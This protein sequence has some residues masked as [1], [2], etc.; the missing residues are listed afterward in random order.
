MTQRPELDLTVVCAVGRMAG[1][2]GAIHRAF[3]EVVARTD[4]T[5]EFV[6]VLHGSRPAAVEALLRTPAGSIPRRIF[7][8]AKGFGEAAA[9]DLGFSRARGR[10]VI[11]IPERLQVEPEDLLAVVAQLERGMDVV[12]TRREPRR[13]PW[14]NRFQSRVFHW[15]TGASGKR[16]RDM[17]C[18]LRGFTVDACR[19]LELYGDIHR[20][21]PVIAETRGFRVQ[22]I[23]VRQRL[24]DAQLRVFGPGLYLRRL[25]DILH[26]FFLTKFTRKP[27]RFFGLVGFTTAAVG[28]AI[29]AFLTFERLT[30]KTSLADRPL[31]LLGVLLLA[32][33]IQVI[34]IG[35]IGEIV[36]FFGNK[37]REIPAVELEPEEDLS[38]EHE[39]L[40]TP[41]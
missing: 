38:S 1:D 16:F 10:L 33:G 13:D 41:R 36:I 4:K 6:Y 40:R 25:L 2:L 34:S 29:T 19:A 37:D 5:A 8:M 14:P 12:V 35:L 3:L 32:L 23:P 11:T 7:Q 9:L 39:G 30:G 22:E 24:E 21:I 31:L 20:F 15:L 17:T 27:L 28:F 26:I 18:G